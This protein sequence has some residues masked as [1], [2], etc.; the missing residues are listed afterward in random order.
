MLKINL[1]RIITIA[2]IWLLLG[3]F[4]TAYDLLLLKSQLSNGHSVDY[5]LSDALL[6]NMLSGFFGG[7]MG[8]AGPYYCQSKI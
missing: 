8:G 6:F 4:L 1:K 7:L 5:T 2:V 3:L